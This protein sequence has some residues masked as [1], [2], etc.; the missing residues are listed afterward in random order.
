MRGAAIASN[1][2]ESYYRVIARWKAL[3]ERQWTYLNDPN[4]RTLLGVTDADRNETRKVWPSVLALLNDRGISAGPESFSGWNDGDPALI[5]AIWCLL[6][7]LDAAKVV[8]TGVANGVTSRFILEWCAK[9]NRDARLWSIDLPPLDQQF[10]QQIAAAV[11]DRSQW[12]F[13]KGS[14]RRR[15]PRLLK[16]IAPIDLF[17]HDSDHRQYNMAFE[18]RL[19]WQALRRGGALVVDDIDVNAAYHE[20]TDGIACDVIVGEAEPIRPDRRR[21]NEKGLFGIVFK[22]NG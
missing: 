10:A 16:E 1:P 3:N 4:W 18:M 22:P 13:I 12:T 5:D 17:I 11:I 6:R 14:S 19:A 7:R 2:V 8:E 9:N 20:F 21:F 15:L